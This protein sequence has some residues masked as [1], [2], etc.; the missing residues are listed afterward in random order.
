[1]TVGGDFSSPDPTPGPS[2]DSSVDGGAPKQEG[3]AYRYTSFLHRM[4]WA[5]LLCWLC[6]AGGLAYPAMSFMSK[7]SQSFNA[8]PG[9]Q[10]KHAQDAMIKYFPE[11]GLSTNVIIYLQSL[12]AS[13]DD[14][15][16][17]LV[18]RPGLAEFDRILNKSLVERFGPIPGLISQYQSY[19]MLAQMGL[20]E[21]AL[22]NLVSPDGEATFIAVSIN[23]LSTDKRS[24][25]VAKYMQ[26]VLDAHAPLIS[27]AQAHGTPLGL[28]SFMDTIVSSA[29]ENLGT[30]DAISIPL[31]MCVLAY[32]LRSWR[33][34]VLPLVN[35]GVTAAVSFGVMSLVADHMNVNS[36]A[37]SLMMSILVAMSIDYSLFLLTRYRDE[38]R[39][40]LPPLE[41]EQR[42]APGLPRYRLECIQNMVGTAGETIAVSALTLGVC[43][44]ALLIFPMNFIQSI[45]LA[46]AITICIA[47]SSNISIT[48]AALFAFAG[49]FERCAEP[50]RCCGAAELE[51][52]SDEEDSEGPAK[53]CADLVTPERE[54]HHRIAHHRARHLQDSDTLVTSDSCTFRSIVTGKVVRQPSGGLPL[55]WWR[56]GELTQPPRRRPGDTGCRNRVPW[57]LIIIVVIV[58]A[59]VWFD[60]YAFGNAHTDAMELFL[61]R[62]APVTRAYAD[63]STRFGLGKVYPI[64]LL[65]VLDDDAP[66]PGVETLPNVYEGEGPSVMNDQFYNAARETI[67]ESI[68][69]NV[70]YVGMNDIIAPM[71]GGGRPVNWT[72][73][74]FCNLMTNVLWQGWSPGGADCD[75]LGPTGS[76][77]PYHAMFFNNRTV[78]CDSSAPPSS[79]RSCVQSERGYCHQCQALINMNKTFT[80]L[81][82]RAMYMYLNPLTDPLGVEGERLHDALMDM[83][84]MWEAKLRCKIYFSGYNAIVWETVQ[85]LF[86]QFPLMIALECAV[87]FLILGTVFK[88]L[89]IPLRAVCTIGLTLAW[90]FGFCD[91]VY[92]HNLLGWMGITAWKGEGAVE[93]TNTIVLFS[94]VVG[95]GLDY[96]IFLLTRIKEYHSQGVPTRECIRQGLCDTGPIIT[97][98]GII[99]AVAFSG[100]FVSDIAVLNQMGFYLVFSVLFETF[101][102]ESL[103][104]PSLMGLL[105]EWNWWPQGCCRR[106]TGPEHEGLLDRV[107]SDDDCDPEAQRSPGDRPPS[108]Q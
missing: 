64:T 6:L 101:V 74:S 71:Y 44:L 106:A 46:N 10:S 8:L 48:P 95:I 39:R 15:E 80:S 54:T 23:A 4:R 82:G 18:G 76:E 37:P 16:R 79:P 13:A 42:F 99:M 24:T 22:A 93:W 26:A 33:L 27:G 43:F 2:P 57:N 60:M 94:M 28:P 73:V 12:N 96:D 68:P 14:D 62:G 41:S 104:S 100:L 108:P 36:V 32:I 31:A 69:G 81:D 35:M 45:G 20:E 103:L 88:S 38:V 78:G 58:A 90:T 65:V 7:T 29:E 105:G 49:F 34:L 47:L 85:K 55:F 107:S 50:P 5:V 61:P 11:Q 25:D 70:P 19:W 84:P 56:L 102:V 89:L 98:A 9:T 97:A 91:L 83:R 67:L 21:Q 75:D 30:I 63:M 72:Y 92:E 87:V 17:A 86:G 66:F 59:T 3:F 40:R 52:E 77:D 51:A 1:M 53:R